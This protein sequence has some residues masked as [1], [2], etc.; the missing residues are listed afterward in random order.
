MAAWDVFRN[1]VGETEAAPS[2]TIWKASASCQA[3]RSTSFAWGSEASEAI[4]S[5]EAGLGLV[6]VAADRGAGSD[7][8]L[9]SLG[10]RP[11]PRFRQ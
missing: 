3:E 7:D 10:S 5:I 1:A 8:H 2:L 11:R 9:A 6:A 4:E